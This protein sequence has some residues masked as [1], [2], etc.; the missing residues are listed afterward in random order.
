MV[1]L[2]KNITY[3]ANEI[4]FLNK[5]LSAAEDDNLFLILNGT[6][7]KV[8]ILDNCDGKIEDLPKGYILKVSSKDNKLILTNIQNSK[9]FEE[10]RTTSRYKTKIKLD[11]T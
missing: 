6:E 7:N 8:K 3:S 1:I 9:S 11:I 5:F 2:N 10:N 4:I